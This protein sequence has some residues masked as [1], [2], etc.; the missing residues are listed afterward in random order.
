MIRFI[1]PTILT[2]LMISLFLI[3]IPLYTINFGLNDIGARANLKEMKRN[4]ERSAYSF[5]RLIEAEVQQITKMM[6][7]SAI[8][9]ALLEVERSKMSAIRSADVL[10]IQNITNDV[11]RSSRFIKQT[12]LYLPGHNAMVTY[13]AYYSEMDQEAFRKYSAAS[14][15][16][17]TAWEDGG[18]YLVYPYLVNARPRSS[19]VLVV[20]LN[21]PSLRY[22]MRDVNGYEQGGA[23]LFHAEQNWHFGSLSRSGFY[24]DLIAAFRQAG[25]PETTRTLTV[26]G[27]RYVVSA[28]E[29]S[30]LG[31]TML[32]YTPQSVMLRE[33]AS[34]RKIFQWML[35]ASFVIIVGVSIWIY[36]TVHSPLKLLVKA[37]RDWE[38]EASLD[39]TSQVRPEYEDEFGYI[40]HRF[41]ITIAKLKESIHNLYV[42]EIERQ[43]AELKRLQSQIDPHF[44]YN[45]FFVLSRLLRREDTET[46][47]NF[48]RFLGRYFQ[49]IT[50]HDSDEIPL[51]KEIEHAKAYAEIQMICYPQIE[52]RFPDP[53]ETARLTQILVPRLILQPLLENCYKHGF[54]DSYTNGKIKFS[55]EEADGRLVFRVEDN[56]GG[57]SD[58]DIQELQTRV[59]QGNETGTGLVNVHHRVRLRFKGESGL[60][61]SRSEA[62]GGLCV[63]LVIRIPADGESAG[64]T[65]GKG[66]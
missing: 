60:R 33:T 41:N 15:L 42:T 66:G 11:Q 7:E 18:V 32:V 28:D 12:T 16:T 2:K 27:I 1:K 59:H 50:R 35:A 14:P 8:D 47:A 65:E 29:S 23:V 13:N 51:F 9:I 37:M 22:L 36:R 31:T 39:L 53:E 5:H 46:A 57:M 45:A 24:R 30:L 17:L 19:F 52:V 55:A 21:E 4:M 44:L 49:Y 61:F 34:Y 6:T 58:R 10:E 26:D 43:R 56:G 63:T 40:Y 48:A 54:R 62:L 3:V 20:E 64:E 25:G 38:H